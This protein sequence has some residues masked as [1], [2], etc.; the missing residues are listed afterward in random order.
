MRHLWRQCPDEGRAIK[1]QQQRQQGH[2]RIRDHLGVSALCRL[3]N[4][5]RQVIYCIFVRCFLVDRP[6]WQAQ[7]QTLKE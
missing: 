2:G 7:N 6:S 5:F 4:I 1:R 3:I